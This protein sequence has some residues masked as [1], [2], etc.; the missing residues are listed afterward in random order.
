[1]ISGRILI[2]LSTSK[3]WSWKATISSITAKCDVGAFGQFECVQHATPS[4]PPKIATEAPIV[5]EE[6][7]PGAGRISRMSV[8]VGNLVN[9][10]YGPAIAPTTIV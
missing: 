10:V 2:T 8:T 9:G 5:S 6:K 1:M 3:R 4:P 7:A